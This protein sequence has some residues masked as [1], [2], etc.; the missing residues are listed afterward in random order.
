MSSWFQY[1]ALKY[2]SFPT[3]VRFLGGWCVGMW[4][5]GWCVGGEGRCVGVCWG[6][7]GGSKVPFFGK[8]GVS[9]SHPW[10][11]FLDLSRVPYVLY[12]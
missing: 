9:V 5:G 3:Q 4:V 1:E 12:G 6:L 8:L 2:V 10:V 11:A 7:G